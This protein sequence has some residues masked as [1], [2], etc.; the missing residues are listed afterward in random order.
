MVELQ[1]KNNNLLYYGDKFLQTK[2]SFRRIMIP[3]GTY[4]SLLSK[5]NQKMNTSITKRRNPAKLSKTNYLVVIALDFETTG[6]SVYQDYIL[7]YAFVAAD[8]TIT[9]RFITGYVQL[10]NR[11]I[12]TASTKVHHITNDLVRNAPTYKDMMNNFKQWI[13]KIGKEKT[14]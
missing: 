5:F 6:R 1:Q 7:K 14:I 11:F 10:D 3:L 13:N 12:P 8:E 9:S 4:L 2:L